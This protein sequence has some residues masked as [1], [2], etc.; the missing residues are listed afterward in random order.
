MIIAHHLKNYIFE[1]GF[2]NIQP[3]LVITKNI[4]NI[5]E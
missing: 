1:I 2:L 3:T 5:K 4:K